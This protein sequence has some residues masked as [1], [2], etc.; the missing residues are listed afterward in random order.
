MEDREKIKKEGERGGR[1]RG[2]ITRRRQ[3]EREGVD[4]KRGGIRRR[5]RKIV[6]EGG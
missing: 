4:R 6:R 5:R 3:R 1:Q 2:G